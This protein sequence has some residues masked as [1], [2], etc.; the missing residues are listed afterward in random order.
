KIGETLEEDRFKDDLLLAI[1]TV[2][3]HA[4]NKQFNQGKLQA[5]LKHR[6]ALRKLLKSTDEDAR[7]MAMEYL[8]WLDRVDDAVKNGTDIS[9]LRFAP[10]L[11]KRV[12]VS[13]K[14]DAEF[15]VRKTKVQLTYR[16]LAKGEITVLEDD[17][18]NTKLFRRQMKDGEQYNIEF[19]DG[20]LVRYRPWSG[21]NLYAQR[22]ELEVLSPGGATPEKVE[23]IMERLDTLGLDAH[24]ATAS[25]AERMYLE[26]MA[27]VSK[28]DKDSKWQVLLKDLDKREASDEVRVAELRRFWEDKIGVSNLT[29]L[30][31]YDPQGEYQA[32]FKD[33]QRKG[34]YR[35]QMR[36]DISDEEIEREMKGYALKHKLTNGEKVD[37]FVELVLENN[38]AMIS[39]VEKLRAGVAPGGM[40]PESDMD[41]GGASYF[42]TRIHKL[43]G[44][45]APS[46]AGLY[47]KKRLLR[48][49]DAISYDHDAYGRVTDDYVASRRGST[50]KDWK[51]FA[52][53]SGNETIIKNS[54]MLL[55]DIELI[56]T[57]SDAERKR[58]L[59]SFHKR[60]IR[61]LPDGRDVEKIVV[62]RG[63][64][65]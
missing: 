29:R 19:E 4:A 25:Q 2:N 14:S 43:P 44:Q 55:D 32:G 40:S 54:V 41:S 24:V 15:T 10:Y 12:P 36:F 35:Q 37:G 50:P 34:G 45:G 39:T 63:G 13:T 17:V 65:N 30:P 5:A 22:G 64:G 48:R 60:G 59:G 51:A 28:V 18:A 62:V 33:L 21:A 53:Q 49:M 57:G 42:F 6:G 16:S 7:E 26:K 56:V 61:R 38:G 46:E 9:G 47:F 8:A 58:T 23:R 11:R 52:R 1:K 20:M 31:G 3:H 27:Y